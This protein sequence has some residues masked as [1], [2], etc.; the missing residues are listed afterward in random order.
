MPYYDDPL[1]MLQPGYIPPSG[2]P[3]APQASIQPSLPGTM[4]W[5]RHPLDS[6]K[7]WATG[8]TQQAPGS[9]LNQTPP[10]LGQAAVPPVPQPAPVTPPAAPPA[11]AL[12]SAMAPP[13]STPAPDAADA[14]SQAPDQGAPMPVPPIPP[15]QPPA[16]PALSAAMSPQD[17]SAAPSA[18]TA[19]DGWD[20]VSNARNNPLNL[21]FAGQKDATDSKG[22]AAFPTPDAGLAAT[23]NQFALYAKRGINTLNGLVSTWAPPNENDTAAYIN[24]VS[25]VTGI[26]PDAKIDLT[27]PALQK[28]IMAAM[29]RVENGPGGTPGSSGTQVASAAPTDQ[30]TL[31]S[32][33]TPVSPATPPGSFVNGSPSTGGDGLGDGDIQRLLKSI[34]PDASQQLL[35]LASGLL[36]GPT[37]GQ[38]LGKGLQAMSAQDAQYRNIAMQAAQARATAGYRSGMLGNAQQRIGVSQQKADQSDLVPQVVMGPN[39]VPM[40]TMVS[41]TATAAGGPVALPGQTAAQ[42]TAAAATQNADS[43]ATQAQTGQ[44]RLDADINGPLSPEAKVAATTN[45]K[46]LTAFST[47]EASARENVRTIA[48][49]QAILDKEGPNGL[50]G[51]D[52]QSKVKR[53]F[54][55]SLG[56]DVGGVSPSGVSLA[57]KDLAA[58]RNGQL[59]GQTKGSVPRSNAE[60]QAL[61]AGMGSLDQNP[62]ALGAILQ[63]DLAANQRLVRAGEAWRQMSPADQKAALAQNNG[64]F[65]M[66]RDRYAADQENVPG[67]E[68]ATPPA[69]VSPGPGGTGW[70]HT[71]TGVRWSIQ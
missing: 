29:S 2:S 15:A 23:Q 28:R 54:A 22:F 1:A 39:G 65:S 34:R 69:R 68:G 31:S 50:A 36:S 46:D 26:A 21:R 67:Q 62:A 57:T 8:T 58:L 12:S 6:Y 27:D 3:A 70:Q 64:L 60:L 32:T 11:P 71:S 52:V 44:Q 16:Q 30:T 51:P 55:N 40:V 14:P 25:G 53:Y 61:Q 56:I 42:T 35:S 43:R 41:K 17:P 9:F 66:W 59:L 38:G 10:S 19:P 20:L 4:D 24:T 7:A 13:A 48:D 18:P 49:L 63:R 33:S 47:Q 5:L 37:F 45:A